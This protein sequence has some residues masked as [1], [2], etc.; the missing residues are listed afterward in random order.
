MLDMTP[1][2]AEVG[3]AIVR[4][5]LIGTPVAF[6]VMAVALRSVA[7]WWQVALVALWPAL[8]G[9]WFYGGLVAL[10]PVMRRCDR[11]SPAADR[12]RPARRPAPVPA[13]PR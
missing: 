5:A 12:D 11:R 1:T 8:V 3:R 2:D 4:G 9:G 10:A 6:A 7:P 13:S